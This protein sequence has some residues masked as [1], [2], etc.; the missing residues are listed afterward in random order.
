MPVED[1]R[2][3]KERVTDTEQVSAK[4]R[5]ERAD[6]DVERGHD[7]VRD[8]SRDK[9]TGRADRESGRTGRNEV[10]LTAD[11]LQLTTIP[12]PYLGWGSC[13]VH[14]QRPYVWPV[15]VVFRLRG[16]SDAG[17]WGWRRRSRCAMCT[18]PTFG[19]MAVAGLSNQRAMRRCARV[20]AGRRQGVS[21]LMVDTLWMIRV[22]EVAWFECSKA[23]D[24]W[25]GC[26]ASFH[27]CELPDDHP[28]GCMV[29]MRICASSRVEHISHH[30]A[31]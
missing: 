24:R 7:K 3:G 14:E 15:G 31:G 11:P 22:G 28:A 5:K 1:V 27:G 18:R 13:Y 30:T 20:P 23:V 2:V 10:D 16:L 9:G 26:R 12:A 4:L 29:C 19:D 21:R 25:P 8:K 17:R 6:V